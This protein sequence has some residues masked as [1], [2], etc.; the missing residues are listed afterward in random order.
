M[1]QKTSLQHESSSRMAFS[2][3]R[4][5]MNRRENLGISFSNEQSF[6]LYPAQK[7]GHSS[8][9]IPSM[10]LLAN[11]FPLLMQLQITLATL[12]TNT[13][14][15]PALSTHLTCVHIASIQH[16]N[17]LAEFPWNRLVSVDTFRFCPL[18]G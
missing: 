15:F 18:A 17:L 10:S 8:M 16:L 6:S 14:S 11:I 13:H 7:Q 4:L 9:L 5:A 3:L 1:I 2:F 12:Q